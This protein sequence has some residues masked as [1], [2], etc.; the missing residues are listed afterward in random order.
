[1][2]EAGLLDQARLTGVGRRGVQAGVEG[3]GSCGAGLT[4]DLTRRGIPIDVIA[5]DKQLRRLRG[6][7]GQI[8]A[9]NAARAVFAAGPTPPQVRQ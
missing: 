7:T 6:K 3:T 9:H 8:D 4:R 1:M 2:E 5:P